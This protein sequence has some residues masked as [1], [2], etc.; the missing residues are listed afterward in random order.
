M[1][2]FYVCNKMYITTAAMSND[3]KI[4]YLSATYLT[5]TGPIYRAYILFNYRKNTK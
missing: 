5:K 3:V 1:L 2:K 4:A